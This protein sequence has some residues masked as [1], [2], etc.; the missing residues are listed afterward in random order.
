MQAVAALTSELAVS[1]MMQPVHFLSHLHLQQP[2]QCLSPPVTSRSTKPVRGT[3]S[4]PTASSTDAERTL[5]PLLLLLLLLPLLRP[6]LL[7]LAALPS[8]FLE[9][10]LAPAVLLLLAMLLP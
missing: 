4:L 2:M 9:V 5:L 1:G 7:L 3:L 10:V 6:P 8:L